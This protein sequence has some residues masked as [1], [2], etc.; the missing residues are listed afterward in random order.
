MKKL[1][2][3]TIKFE[4]IFENEFGTLDTSMDEKERK[5][6][7]S[8][9]RKLLNT[10]MDEIA[11]KKRKLQAMDEIEVLDTSMDEIEM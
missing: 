11:S 6:Q 8:K 9:K 10:S 7:A 1:E 5:L 2:D 3:K 4:D